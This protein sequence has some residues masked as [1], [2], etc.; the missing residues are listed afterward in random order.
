[1]LSDRAKKILSYPE[2]DNIL[3]TFL[4][5]S[6]ETIGFSLNGPFGRMVDLPSG[7]IAWGRG[8]FA[9]IGLCIYY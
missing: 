2:N 3:V 5:I 6:I 7:V 1:M 4:Y 9:S 8:L